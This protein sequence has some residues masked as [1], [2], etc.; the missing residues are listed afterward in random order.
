V[1]P[2]RRALRG[3]RN[4]SDHR[5]PDPGEGDDWQVSACEEI[6][7]LGL[8]NPPTRAD[9]S[10]YKHDERARSAPRQPGPGPRWPDADEQASM[11]LAAMVA[12]GNDRERRCRPPLAEGFSMPQ[13]HKITFYHF[14]TED[15]AAAIL[16]SG[17]FS[18]K[19]SDD[20]TEYA[21]G[22]SSD[23]AWAGVSLIEVPDPE[24]AEATAEEDTCLKVTLDEADYTDYE[25]IGL[26][27]FT[28]G[29]MWVIPFDVL[30]TAH[31]TIERCDEDE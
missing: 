29:R 18:D 8:E 11:R 7:A 24:V 17:R 28:G 20:R 6:P 1:T 9:I 5:S 31:P 30:T 27:D 21:P 16:A 10:A 4:G 12:V 3:V 23:R 13:P 22:G 15:R 26:A 2:F 25:A 19:F 14:T